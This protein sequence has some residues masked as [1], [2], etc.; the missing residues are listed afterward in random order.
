MIIDVIKNVKKLFSILANNF[1]K[2]VKGIRDLFVYSV[3]MVPFISVLVDINSNDVNLVEFL[4]SLA[5]TGI[6]ATLVGLKHHGVDIFNKIKNKFNNL[7][8]KIFKKNE[9]HEFNEEFLLESLIPDSARAPEVKI[10]K[11]E[12]S[13]M[14][15]LKIRPRKISNL[16]RDLKLQNP[17]LKE[18][19]SLITDLFHRDLI[20][21]GDDKLFYLTDSGEELISK[22]V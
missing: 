18:L 17:S 22:F 9:F 3:L 15:K 14:F 11:L 12:F 6:G 5:L 16:K 10:T 8:M 4:R 13:V 7:V 20:K 2:V 19:I 1:G 21:Q